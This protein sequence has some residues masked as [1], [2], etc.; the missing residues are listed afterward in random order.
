MQK[1]L[2]VFLTGALLVTSVLGFTSCSSKQKI[3]PNAITKVEADSNWFDCTTTEITLDGYESI[4]IMSS[5]IHTDDGYAAA[6]DAYRD[7]GGNGG[8]GTNHEGVVELNRDGTIK[9]IDVITSKDL[10]FD[11][12]Y[13][14]TISD[15]FYKDGEII[16]TVYADYM[17]METYQ[18]D[19][20][21]FVYNF[22]QKE[23]VDTSAYESSFPE[24]APL[25]KIKFLDS[26][27]VAVNDGYYTPA[28]LVLFEGEE[29]LFAFNIEKEIPGYSHVDNL[30]LNGSSIIAECRVDDDSGSR[31]VNY[32]INLD[33]LSHTIEDSDREFVYYMV[34]INNSWMISYVDSEGREYAVKSDGVYM[35]DELVFDFSDTYCNPYRARSGC[36][37]DATPDHFVIVVPFTEVHSLKGCVQVMTFDKASSN[38]NAGKTILTVGFMGDIDYAIGT[39]ISKFNASN[40]EYY[41]KA[42]SYNATEEEMNL[43][44]GVNSRLTTEALVTNKLM[45]DLLNGDGPDILLNTANFLQLNNDDYLIDL[46]SFMD[47]N[48]E[49]GVLFDNV[50]EAMAVEGKLYQVPVTFCV[51]GIIVESVV[52]NGRTGFTFDEY[53]EYVR[54]TCNGKNPIA[55]YGGQVET[56]DT[57]YGPMSNLMYDKNGNVDMNN[58]AFSRIATYCLN[59]IGDRIELDENLDPFMNSPKIPSNSYITVPFISQYLFSNPVTRD[60]TLMGIPSVD[61]RGPSISSTNSVAI[62]SACCDLD[63][64]KAFVKNLFTDI[65]IYAEVNENPLLVEAT[66]N[67][68]TMLVEFYNNYYQREIDRNPGDKEAEAFLNSV[69]FY[70]Y[71][72]SVIDKYIELLKS[73]NCSNS[74]DSDILIIIN[75]EIQSYFAD[76]KSLDEVISIIENRVQTVID[77]RG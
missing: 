17:D 62:S 67:Y 35:E 74:V 76:Q 58:E 70:H 34:S 9:N 19:S 69:G 56:F 29:E 63:G 21:D 26:Y 40:S 3:T 5:F 8:N 45:M 12:E 64:A 7:D 30:I 11:K 46:A 68:A 66:K 6:F 18:Y 24:E 57:L 50:L 38:P 52:S 47:E 41:V 54:K 32:I 31:Y 44:S 15:V 49:D 53:D 60:I 25:S 33:N 10:G 22:T 14:C 27:V 73:A 39:S 20:K 16:C 23:L 2:S 36:L 51:N 13:N 71:D 42:V 75:E 43:G 48:F 55:P 72:M 37:I 28:T 59:N 1:F 61:G 4:N 65:D 77:E